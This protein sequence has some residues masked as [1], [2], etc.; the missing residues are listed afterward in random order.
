MNLLGWDVYCYTRSPVHCSA[1]TGS[2]YRWV[3]CTRYISAAASGPHEILP[4]PLKR[5]E[6]SVCFIFIV[7]CSFP[8]PPP[9]KLQ[10]ICSFLSNGFV[11]LHDKSHPP[12][13]QSSFLCMS[14]WKV[15]LV[16]R[17]SQPL[18]NV[19]LYGFGGF[20]NSI[21]P[22]DCIDTLSGV[23]RTELINC[24]LLRYWTLSK[25]AIMLSSGSGFCSI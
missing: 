22:P 14:P 4:K 24:S 15:L 1:H 5:K 11:Q 18:F 12:K 23:V 3:V 17:A 8:F 13:R 6:S 25:E 7:V 9:S 19:K 16:L 2:N 20:P 21:N 10:Q